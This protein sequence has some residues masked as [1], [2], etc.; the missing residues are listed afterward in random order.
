MN[1]IQLVYE[2][3]CVFVET[4]V[5]LKIWTQVVESIVPLSYPSVP[6]LKQYDLF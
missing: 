5:P 1:N 6:S 4:A 3:F 2:K